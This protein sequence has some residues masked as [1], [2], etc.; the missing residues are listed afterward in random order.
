MGAVELKLVDIPEMNYSHLD[1]DENGNNVPRGEVCVRGHT[2]IPGYYKDK[3]RTDE[4]IDKDGWLHTGD[5]GQL[6]YPSRSLQIIDRKKNI[7]KL[8]QGEYIAPDRL[9]QMYKTTMGVA[10]IYVYGDSY[11]SVLVAIVNPD[12][13]S[14]VKC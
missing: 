7:F 10:D 13:M 2:V 5:I 14:F 6:M 11:K 12:P 3:E 8:S 4:A 1:K 9:E